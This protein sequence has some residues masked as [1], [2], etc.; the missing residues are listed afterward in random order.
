M[1]NSKE[2]FKLFQSAH[3]QNARVQ[4]LQNTPYHIPVLV[5]FYQCKST[6][7][8]SWIRNL[9]WFFLCEKYLQKAV[10]LT[11][12]VDMDSLLHGGWWTVR[13]SY[14]PRA[15]GEK[16]WEWQRT[17]SQLSGGRQF[18]LVCTFLHRSGGRLDA[19]KERMAS[20]QTSLCRFSLRAPSLRP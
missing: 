8:T 12:A 11:W 1:N 17:L 19:V 20:Q 18:L 16:K 13:S 3:V 15:S 4:K 2:T 5:I 14:F 10:H 6:I 9:W 7:W